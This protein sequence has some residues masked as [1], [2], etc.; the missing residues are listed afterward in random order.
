MTYMTQATDISPDADRYQMGLLRQKTPAQ[1]YA[2]AA[3]L[4]LA[5]KRIALLQHRR[6][7]GELGDVYFAKSLLREI[8][9]TSVTLTGPAEN[10]V[11]DP[12]EIAQI[13]HGAMTDLAIP[14]FICGG[15]ATL[16]HGEPRTTM[17]LDIVAQ[18]E[19]QDLARV[20][21]LL[22]AQGF[23]CP[24]GAVEE[25]QAGTGRLLTVTHSIT[26]LSA[27][28]AMMQNTDHA[29]SEMSRRQL[30]NMGREVSAWFC[31]P[32]DLILAK[33]QWGLKSDSTKQ[34]R[35]VLAVMKVQEGLLDLVYLRLWAAQLDLSTL[36]EQLL[37]QST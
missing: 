24:H 9:G 34:R 19:R 6:R 3:G 17:D 31:S 32:E 4:I 36:V 11:Q 26:A 29:R 18:I 14:Y 8:R 25:I 23:Y 16:I 5:G 33:L 35:D 21:T 37:E 13:L 30:I 15:V 2:I 12:L 22:E 20:V 28:I 27:D 1:R 10:W 7:R